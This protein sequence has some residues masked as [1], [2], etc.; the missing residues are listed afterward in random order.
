MIFIRHINVTAKDSAL[1]KAFRFNLTN[2]RLLI[3]A[4]SLKQCVDILCRLALAD[5]LK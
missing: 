5:G 3:I 4:K 1:N 2:G